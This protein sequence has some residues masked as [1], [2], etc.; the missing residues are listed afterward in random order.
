MKTASNKFT[1]SF[2]LDSKL[3]TASPK[4]NTGDGMKVCLTHRE[5][6]VRDRFR[7]PKRFDGS[8]FTLPPDDNVDSL[9]EFET[10]RIYSTELMRGPTCTCAKILAFRLAESQVSGRELIRLSVFKFPASTGNT[11]HYDYIHGVHLYSQLTLVGQT[12]NYSGGG[13]EGLRVMDSFFL[14]LKATLRTSIT[15]YVTESTLDWSI[16]N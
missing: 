13:I 8:L 9:D 4:A 2:S 6:E 15:Q 7:N 10:P 16:L 14:A 1:Y 11:C 12:T 5:S 3:W